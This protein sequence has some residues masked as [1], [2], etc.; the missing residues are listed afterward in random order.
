MAESF[1][2]LKAPSE[3]SVCSAGI[4]PDAINPMTIE[5]MR[6]VGIDLS[7]RR[8]KNLSELNDPLFDVVITLCRRSYESCPVL[9]G[10]PP[11]INWNMPDPEGISG[12]KQERLEAFRKIRDRIRHFVDEFFDGGYYSAFIA[13]KEDSQLLLDNISDAIIAHDMNRRIYY[14]NTAAEK[15]T[16]YKR[17]EVINRD[18]H[19]AFGM[20]LCGEQCLF[21]SGKY[22]GSEMPPDNCRRTLQITGKNGKKLIC[23]MTIKLMLGRSGEPKGV[24]ATLRDRRLESRFSKYVTGE[25]IFSGFVGASPEIIEVIDSI[26]D[27]ADSSAAVLV[28]GESGTGKEMVA[29][30]IHDQ[31]GR[32]DKLFVPINCGAL[33]ENLLESELFGHV[34][35][36]FTGAIRDKKGRFELAD[37]G[38]IFL[39]E[40]GD[41]SQAMQV[42][43]LR[44]LQ[45]GTFERV[46][47]EDTVNV[48]V[49]VVSA[50]NK[51]LAVEIAE[52][53]F[54]EDLFYR[55]GVIPLRL[56]PLRERGGDVVMLAEYLLDKALKQSSRSGIAFSP[57]VIDI[58]LSY[59][60]PGNIRELQ[61]WIQYA[62][63]KCK[64]GMIEP[65]HLPHFSQP[66]VQIN[67]AET[68]GRERKK[69]HRKRKLSID[70]VRAA[71]RESEGNKLKAAKLLGV[72]RATLY[73]FLDDNKVSQ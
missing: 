2:Q 11:V 25:K 49:R 58:F 28:C 5:V 29:R 70:A 24:I 65:A 37:G 53:R 14:F 59:K 20:A 57:E 48:D 18:C 12:S 56:P 35:G 6:E 62:L 39:D 31:S 41:I 72:G 67:L 22:K 47:G 52:G 64:G 71:L 26:K 1:A 9:P 40:I 32:R 23:D 7:S 13:A 60:W 46:G 69:R 21:C 73:R 10:N 43:L 66:V 63:I 19:D 50:T 16:G 3:V 51:D 36:A 55:L 38:T 33:P 68:G 27:I 44:V 34:K 15:L 17:N 54:R 8:A 4:D 42:K 61:N 45:E 30:A